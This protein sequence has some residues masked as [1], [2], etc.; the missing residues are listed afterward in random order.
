MSEHSEALA[1]RVQTYLGDAPVIGAVLVGG[2]SYVL[3]FVLTYLFVVFDS[4]L[5]TQSTSETAI[6]N[7][8]LFQQSQLAGF[9]Q[10]EPTT[11]E[12]VGWVFYNAHFADTVI[13]PEVARQTAQSGAETQT[14]PETI[15]FLSATSTQIPG[16]VYQL[17]PVLLLTAGGYA[18]ARAAH[19]AVSRDIIR[20]GLGV[21]VGYVPLGLAGAFLFR[22]SATAERDGLELIVTA[23]P[24]ILGLVTMALV[25]ILFGIAGL[26]LGAQ[27]GESSADE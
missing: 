21:P 4:G 12:F 5:N 16:V 20:I 3:G 1:G 26:Y 27:R 24:S 9:P 7:T 2:G 13:T 17:V 8:E 14:A 10:P 11:T 22:T 18:L 15:N 6:S 23:S 25:S 19:L